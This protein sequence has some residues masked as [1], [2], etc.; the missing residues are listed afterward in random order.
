MD[1]LPASPKQ[2]CESVQRYQRNGALVEWH[3]KGKLNKAGLNLTM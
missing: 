2:E 3:V 1:E